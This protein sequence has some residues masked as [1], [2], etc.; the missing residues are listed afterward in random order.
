MRES[1]SLFCAGGSA[2]PRKTPQFDQHMFEVIVSDYAM[3]TDIIVQP[4]D[5]PENKD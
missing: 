3:R 1:N 2:V 5:I 4:S